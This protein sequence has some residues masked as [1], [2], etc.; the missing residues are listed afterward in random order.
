[1]SAA[2]RHVEQIADVTPTSVGC[3]DWWWYHIDDLAFE[4]DDAPSVTHP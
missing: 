3:A 2:C 4:L 1:M